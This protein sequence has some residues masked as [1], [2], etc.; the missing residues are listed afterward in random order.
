M[1]SAIPCGQ[2]LK[3]AFVLA[4]VIMLS[5]G[6][7]GR[8][9]PQGEAVPPPNGAG[10]IDLLSEERR[11]YWE[12]VTDDRE[13]FSISNHTLH[14]PGRSVYPLR[15]VGYTKQSFAN[16]ELYLQFK[17]SGWANSGVFLRSQYPAGGHRGFEVQIL[18]DHGKPPN[19]RRTGAIYD[20][21]TPMFNLSQQPGEWNSLEIRVEGHEVEVTLNGWR[22]IDA[23]LGK[24][25]MPLGKFDTP[26]A[27]APREGYVLLQ[28]HG[29]E[30]WF[31]HIHVRE[32]D[33]PNI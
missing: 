2:G 26:F 18:D 25:T 17:V 11:E 15:Y 24:M 3:K 10:W 16:F 7:A 5:A 13:I 29:G 14:I 22:V 28:D 20:V 1:R 4:A 23:D 19:T 33:P 21:V 8:P 9:Q 12:N 27:E 31:R 30:V 6:C 32:L